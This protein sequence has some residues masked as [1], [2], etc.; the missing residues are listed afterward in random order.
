MGNAVRKTVRVNSE[1]ERVL[2]GR[3][4]GRLRNERRVEQRKKPLRKT[5]KQKKQLQPDATQGKQK[6]TTVL[7]R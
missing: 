5:E 4:D 1:D 2:P 7:H 6:Q 3:C